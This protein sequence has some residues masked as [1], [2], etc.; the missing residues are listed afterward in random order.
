MKVCGDTHDIIK[1]NVNHND[2]RNVNNTY[3]DVDDDCVGQEANTVDKQITMRTVN[4]TI[5][6]TTQ[7]ISV[8]M[9]IT[10]TT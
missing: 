6:L 4:G 9:T 5:R 8:S 2:T 10:R 7:I 1:G 3:L